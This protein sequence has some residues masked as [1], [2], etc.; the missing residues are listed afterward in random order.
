VTTPAP[1]SEAD[2]RDMSHATFLYEL[3]EIASSGGDIRQ[4]LFG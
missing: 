1:A 4:R 3:A 2:G